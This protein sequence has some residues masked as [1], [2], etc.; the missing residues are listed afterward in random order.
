MVRLIAISSC[1]LREV[2]FRLMVAYGVRLIPMPCVHCHINAEASK[3]IDN[4]VFLLW[5]S[6]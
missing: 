4:Y 2:D 1:I 3:S 5:M 6:Q